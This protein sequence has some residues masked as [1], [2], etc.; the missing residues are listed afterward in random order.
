MRSLM[1]GSGCAA[2]AFGNRDPDF[3]SC[4]ENVIYHKVGSVIRPFTR[5]SMLGAAAMAASPALAQ[6]RQCV[7]GPPPH[8]KGPRVGMDMDQVKLDAAYDQAY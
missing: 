1:G 7:V 5:R 4:E 6:T 2:C 3:S 8:A